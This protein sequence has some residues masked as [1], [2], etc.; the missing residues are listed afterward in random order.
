MSSKSSPE[1]S[2]VQTVV[3][4]AEAND[5]PGRQKIVR[6]L[7]EASLA[8]TGD[9]PVSSASRVGRLG[10]VF[11]AGA[12]SCM[13]AQPNGVEGTTTVDFGK[14]KEASAAA[15]VEQV[16]EK[17]VQV[18][19]ILSPKEG[20]VW[21]G[22]AQVFDP[23][24]RAD[25]Y[26]DTAQGLVAGLEVHDNGNAGVVIE[27]TVGARHNVNA[28]LGKGDG[29]PEEWEMTFMLDGQLFVANA[30]PGQRLVF[31]QPMPSMEGQH[32]NVYPPYSTAE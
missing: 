16:Q 20:S 32:V 2:G 19:F 3:R 15:T 1:H 17:R 12:L 21:D 22:S 10:T 8:R 31:T 27:L 7:Q 14:T 6:G 5:S 25:P 13:P 29:G 24:R 4:T 18:Q 30:Q 9:R 28:I 11:A 26:I 23:D